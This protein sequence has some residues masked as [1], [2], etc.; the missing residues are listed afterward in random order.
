VSNAAQP[1][2]D[3]AESDPERIALRGAGEPWTYHAL[4][5][6]A[7]AV[8]GALLAAG[9]QPGDRI[10]FVAPSVLEFVAVYYGIHAA[11]AVA[12]TANTMSTTP[13]LEYVGG[14]AGVALVIGWSAIE[15]APAAAATKLGVPFW[16][17]NEDMAGLET[18]AALTSPH[19]T[20][21]DD[22]AAILYTSGTTGK[23]KGAELTHGNLIAGASIFVEVHG[24]TPAD[25]LGTALPLFHA[26]G[27]VCVMATA[28]CAGSSLSLLPQFDAESMVAMLRRDQLT[29][30]A[31]VPTMWNGML[32]AGGESDTSDF[33]S[34][35]IA[36][37]GGAALPVEV[38]RAFEDRF[39]CRIL[40]GY[41][42]TEST[43]AALFHGAERPRKP[44]SV[45][46]ALPRCEMV[47]RDDDGGDLPA[48]EVGELYFRGPVVMKGYWHRPQATAEVLQDGWLRTGDLGVK[49][50]DGDIR[51][52]G[53][54]K[55]LVI[56]GGYNVYPLEVEEV[57]Y[58][59]PD[60]V[61]AAVIGIPDD[62]YG[63]D[64]V[65]V[66]ALRKGVEPDTAAL[67]DWAKER[68]SAYKVPHLIV[69]VP[70]LPKGS[71]GKILKR[72]IDR[73]LIRTASQRAGQAVEKAISG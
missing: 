48:G 51:I 44:G 22:T 39:G 1:V 41:G 59:H 53:R 26:Y 8:G 18:A 27:Q 3:Y 19:T 4:C 72:A 33:A 61:E 30:L 21:D 34:L 69:Y 31:G 37:S 17:L 13:E 10:L 32:H 28:L 2:W 38:S 11:G 58:Q 73:D 64:V 14:D 29:F 40:E 43:A 5:E 25:R 9:I 66:V 15:P 71:T 55:D 45:G 67:R 16:P 54:K 49:D 60:I 46:V 65:A 62:H 68:L 52:V 35:R 50:A 36:A 57:L 47:V 24:L 23:P 42:L 7:R 12:V 20:A 63:E 70:E 56:R 6:R